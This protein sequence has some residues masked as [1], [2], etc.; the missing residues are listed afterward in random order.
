[1]NK[2]EKK[3][4]KEY[5]SKYAKGQFFTDIALVE[6][7]IKNFKIDLNNKKIIEPSCGDCSFVKY[8]YQN[9]ANSSI[10]AVDIDE[11]YISK[12]KHIYK[13]ASF[14]CADFLKAE[15]ND[16]FDIVIGNPPFNLKTSSNY[17]DS[18]EGFLLKG[19]S[20]L[21]PNGRLVM[22]MPSTILRNMQYQ[23]LRKE[24]IENYTIEYIMDTSQYDFLGMDF[25]TIAICIK[26]CRC[27]KQKY[28]YINK[29]GEKLVNWV[30]N[31]R[32]TI[33][34]N[35]L[36]NVKIINNKLS[37][38]TISDLFDIYRGGSPD[39]N[40]IRGRDINF[41]HNTLIT[42]GND[43]FI[44]IQN[45][46]YRFTAN[47]I[48]G[49]V[50]NVKDTVTILY[51]KKSLSLNYLLFYTEFL[52]TSIA[53]YIIH[54]CTLNNS[55]LTIHMDKYYI[56]DIKL[57]KLNQVNKIINSLKNYEGNLEI[58][59]K[60]NNEFYKVLDLNDNMISKIETKWTIPRYSKK[61]ME[62]I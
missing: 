26:A 28:V 45:I 12:N 24:I 16:K 54:E 43:Y 41:F 25:E 10:T 21:K 6:Q 55:K 37:G 51:P 44:G 61:N 14:L 52:N 13:K 47:V 20:L 5:L 15:F 58:A 40:S 2:N 42:K 8:I 17:K 18:T 57:P 11:Y 53:N 7:I 48:Q 59:N 9:S 23:F 62:K 39:I 27:K 34:L 4:T 32:Y 19:L 56:D 36:N 38:D 50:S 3:T 46:A 22:I 31:K 60:R 33:H 29:K 1:M 35:N 30:K 49:N